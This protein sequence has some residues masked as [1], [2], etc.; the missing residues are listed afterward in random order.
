MCTLIGHVHTSLRMR[1]IPLPHLMG[2]AM[3]VSADPGGS[4][5]NLFWS[6]EFE[7]HI[8]ARAGPGLV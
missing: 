6:T 3:P 8:A 5:Q 1:V 2:R 4:L 7:K